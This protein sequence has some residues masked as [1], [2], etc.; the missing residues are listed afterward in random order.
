LEDVAVLHPKRGAVVVELVGE[1]DLGTR[2]DLRELLDV[3]VSDNELAV[4]A[5][6]SSSTPQS[7]AFWLV[8]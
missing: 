5:R 7:S 1:H 4:I 8:G 6:R 3:L 2:A